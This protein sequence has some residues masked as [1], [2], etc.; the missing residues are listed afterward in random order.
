VVTV[1]VSS[2]RDV[3]KLLGPTRPRSL[4]PLRVSVARRIAAACPPLAPSCRIRRVPLRRAAADIGFHKRHRALR[5]RG[6]V[7]GD[8]ERERTVGRTR[9]DPLT[10]DGASP[11]GGAVF[12]IRAHGGAVRSREWRLG[13]AGLRAELERR[14]SMPQV[15]SSVTAPRVGAEDPWPVPAGPTFTTCRDDRRRR[16]Q[17]PLPAEQRDR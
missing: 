10:S 13:R 17:E 1:V 8:Q 11:S 7:T 3:P 15:I 12:A 16:P 2:S 6:G 4:A 9:I 5:A 14:G